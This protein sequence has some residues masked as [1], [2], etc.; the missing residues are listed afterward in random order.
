MSGAQRERIQGP[1]AGY[2][3]H[4]KR[5][6]DTLPDLA[7]VYRV[8]T[9]IAA[10]QRAATEAGTDQ[11]KVG[12]QRQAAAAHNAML[13]RLYAVSNEIGRASCRERV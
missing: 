5:L 8:S 4:H 13:K 11:T 1:P 3:A 7:S 6:K 9:A 12:V 10:A 2:V